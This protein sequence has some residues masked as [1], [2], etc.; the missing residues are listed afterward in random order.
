MF[1]NIS[2][3]NSHKQLRSKQGQNITVILTGGIG[4]V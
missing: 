2:E 4:K 3:K 1:Y